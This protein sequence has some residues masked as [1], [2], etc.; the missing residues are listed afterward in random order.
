MFSCLTHRTRNLAT[1]TGHA[2]N[3]VTV[4]LIKYYSRYNFSHMMFDRCMNESVY[5]AS[6][7]TQGHQQCRP[8]LDHVE[9]LSETTK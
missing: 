2:Q 6:K 8:S 3:H 9:F 1:L 5:R 4:I 7:V